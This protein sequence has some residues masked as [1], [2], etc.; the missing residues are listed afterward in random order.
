[1][2]FVKTEFSLRQTIKAAKNFKPASEAA[3]GANR[4]EFATPFEG[5]EKKR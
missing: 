5:G 1:M 4:M 3:I 2:L